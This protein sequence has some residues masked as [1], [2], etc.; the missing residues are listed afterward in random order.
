VPRY[1]GIVSAQGQAF[2]I[3]VAP[4][5]FP[6][7][8]AGGAFPVERA[9]GVTTWVNFDHCLMVSIFSKARAEDNGQPHL[10]AVPE[11]EDAA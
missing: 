4:D 7:T 3:E 9:D 10:H 8:A 6:N 1:L 5:Y 11:P 2:S